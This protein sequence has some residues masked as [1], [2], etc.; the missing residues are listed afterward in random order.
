MTHVKCELSHRVFA[1]E[2]Y[3]P[4]GR[5]RIERPVCKC[6]QTVFC[7]TQTVQLVALLRVM[8]PL[9]L[10]INRSVL[11]VGWIFLCH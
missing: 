7:N 10:F 9:L 5:R 2:L 11:N 4:S 6:S 8:F 3:R 1:T